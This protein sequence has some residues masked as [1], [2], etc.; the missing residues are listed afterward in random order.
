MPIDQN[1]LREL[2]LSFER[3]EGKRYLPRLDPDRL[4]RG[5]NTIA[6]GSAPV[7]SALRR[8]RGRRNRETS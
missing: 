1:I 7:P 3:L 2:D 4:Y 8:S 5:D 6:F